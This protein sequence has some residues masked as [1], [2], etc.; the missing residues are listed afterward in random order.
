MPDIRILDPDG[1]EVRQLLGYQD[2]E[3]FAEELIVIT[4]GLVV[5]AQSAEKSKPK[6]KDLESVEELKTL[7]NADKGK[8]RLLLLLSPT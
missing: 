7:F 1:I 3:T 8:R 6:M 4:A 5:P 2:V